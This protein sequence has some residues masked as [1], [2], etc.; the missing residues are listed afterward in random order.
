[1]LDTA[2]V[3]TWRYHDNSGSGATAAFTDKDRAEK[4]LQILN[5]SDSMRNFKVEAVPFDQSLQEPT[6]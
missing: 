2:Y 5:D 3:I 6:K 4:L 1:M